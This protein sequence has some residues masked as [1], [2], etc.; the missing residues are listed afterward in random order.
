MLQIDR[1]A[2]SSRLKKYH[3]HLRVTLPLVLLV[4][5]PFVTTCWIGLGT[6]VIASAVN[7]WFGKVPFKLYLESL[8]A[9]AFFVI[10]AVIGILLVT[11]PG[12]NVVLWVWHGFGT[13]APEGAAANALSG[14]SLYITKAS[15]STSILT[16]SRAYGSLGLVYL[17]AFHTTIWELGQYMLKAR[18]PK[19]FVELFVLCYRFI[20]ILLEEGYEMV[21]AQNL[22]L[23]YSDLKISMKSLSL[24]IS[25]LF[26]RT[27]MRVRYMEDSLEMRLYQGDFLMDP[28]EAKSC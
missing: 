19:T 2:H 17:I 9:P 7:L 28:K 4:L 12:S 23:G 5:M 20:F 25:Q 3:P 26:I 8:L 14:F 16:V 18:L 21:H 10:T 11:N 22:R 27:L 24:L 13:S 15:L 6:L 1:I